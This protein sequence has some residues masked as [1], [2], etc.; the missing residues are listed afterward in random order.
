MK[1]LIFSF[2][3]SCLAARADWQLTWTDPNPAGSIR[4]YKIVKIVDGQPVTIATTTNLFWPINL[5]AGQHVVG[6]IASG[7]NA[8][9]SDAVT[10]PVQIL[11]AVV[12]LKVEFK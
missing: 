5:P 8:V 2:L 3:L 6:V 4:E 11:V 1:K 12:N 10:I 9:D 7:V